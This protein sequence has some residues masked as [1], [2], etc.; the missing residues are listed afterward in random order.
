[1]RQMRRIRDGKLAVYEQSCVD[2]GRWVEVIEKPKPEAPR[3]KRPRP[4][5]LRTTEAQV[6]ALFDPA[7]REIQKDPA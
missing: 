4:L 3:R 1:M 5:V 6:M 7:I 2:S